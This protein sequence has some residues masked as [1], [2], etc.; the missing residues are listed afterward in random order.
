M[1][2]AIVVAAVVV[3]VAVVDHGTTEEAILTGTLLLLRYYTN[4]TQFSMRQRVFNSGK[5][6]CKL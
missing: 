4:F 3:A 1:I 6:L 5:L 2:P